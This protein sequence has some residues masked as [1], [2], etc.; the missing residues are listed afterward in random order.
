MNPCEV[1]VTTN[2]IAI[3]IFNSVA[4]E[5]IP[6][7]LSTLGQISTTLGNMARVAGAELAEQ[8]KQNAAKNA[9][10]QNTNNAT[11]N[12]TTNANQNAVNN[13]EENLIDEN[14]AAGDIIEEEALPPNVMSIQPGTVL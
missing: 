6:A 9:I 2:M 8:A 10:G 13:V 3:A 11:T 7:L 14:V 5:D 1:A 4:L 12:N